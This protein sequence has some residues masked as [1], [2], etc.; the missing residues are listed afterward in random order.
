MQ[1]D[2]Q[3]AH[4]MHRIHRQPLDADS[5]VKDYNALLDMITIDSNGS[6]KAGA[7]Y[8]GM[9]VT[10]TDD[11]DTL[12]NGLYIITKGN[13]T[14]EGELMFNVAKVPDD[15]IVRDAIEAAITSSEE[16][17]IRRV[18]EMLYDWGLLV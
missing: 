4:V 14:D 6:T 1:N 7:A 11:E 15:G 12:K 9:L 10:V 17:I 2:I 16:R 13:G 8:P 18:K 3:Q 5:V